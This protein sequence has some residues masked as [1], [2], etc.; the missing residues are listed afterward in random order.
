MRIVLAL[1]LSLFLFSSTASAHPPTWTNGIACIIYSH[2]T[3]CHNPKGIAPFSLTTY[4]DVY[5]NRFSIAASVQAG[6]MPPYPPDTRVRSYAHANTLTDHEKQDLIDWVNQFA[7]LGDANQI[8]APPTYNTEYQLANADVVLRIPTYTVNT[9]SDLYRMFVLPLGNNAMQYIEQIEVVPGNRDIV[10]HALV[11]QDTSDIPWQL[12][13]ADPLPGYSAFGGTRSPSSK[14]ITGYTPGQGV[15]SY[16]PGFGAGILPNSYLCLQIH[17][18]G[19]IN[20]QQ[21][22]TSVRIKFGSSS[23]R[24]VSTIA[25]LNHNISLTNGPLFIPANTVK[26]FYSRTN[27]P[28]NRTI[29]GIMPHMHLLGRS[30]KSFFVKPDGDTVKLIDIPRWDFHWQGFYTFR[31]PIWVPAGSVLHGEATYDNTASNPENPNQPPQ[32]VSLG[33]G[34]ADE[35]MLIYFNVANYQ[36]GD[37]SLIVDTSRHIS[38]W[39]QCEAGVSGTTDPNTVTVA[40]NPAAGHFVVKGLD[41]TFRLNLFSSSGQRVIGYDNWS[42]NQPVKT[43]HLPAGTYYLELITTDMQVFYK[44]ISVSP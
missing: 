27:V 30:I 23:L 9:S 28:V 11:F 35:M 29:T 7:P 31:K 22:S 36:P 6:S 38:H 26:T 12:D 3:G 42:S 8:P 44:I 39:Q 32:D 21:D 37:T 25:A 34:T 10:H 24:N 33:E 17:Y 19:G 16:P 2:C 20:N 5:A 41:R 4:N 15:F 13:Q 40:P 18:P 14:L 1:T 43:S